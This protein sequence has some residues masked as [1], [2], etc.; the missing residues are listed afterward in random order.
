MTAPVTVAAEDAISSDA[1]LLMDELS[2]VLAAI[3]GSSGRASFDPAD[4]AGPTARFAI[5]RDARGAAIGC[6]ALRPL[7]DG[8]AELKRM[9]ARP[10]HAGVGSAV[11]RFL[12]EEAAALG[13]RALWLETR[14]VN[15]R[16]VDFYLARGYRSIPN[17]G[18]Y[19][20]NTLAACFEKVLASR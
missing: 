5:A 18:K 12:E 15:H 3:T 7:R 13:Y 16:A 14:L 6:G 9:Y 4:V 17:Y 8:V 11:L 10:G 1:A 2:Q 19:A 20:G